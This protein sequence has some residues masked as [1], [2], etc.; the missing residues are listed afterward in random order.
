[1]ALEPFV[2]ETVVE[3]LDWNFTPY[4]GVGT[5]AEPTVEQ[6]NEFWAEYLA[7]A[8]S[9]SNRAQ[10]NQR[11]T[12]DIPEELTDEELK[13]EI[14]NGKHQG[15]ETVRQRNEIIAKLCGAVSNDSTGVLEGGSPSLQ[16]IQKL[17]A[18]LQ[19][20]FEGWIIGALTPQA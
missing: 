18:R 7:L 9:I 10:R 16:D 2:A 4:A 13:E 8:R 20:A 14:L 5:V 6:V 11:D 19:L 1:M 12:G 17:P 15:A 3:K